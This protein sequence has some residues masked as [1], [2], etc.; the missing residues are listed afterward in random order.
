M[1]LKK[2]KISINLYVLTKDFYKGYFWKD[3][4]SKTSVLERVMRYK[5]GESTT[6]TRHQFQSHFYYKFVRYTFT[7]SCISPRLTQL[8]RS[9]CFCSRQQGGGQVCPG[10]SSVSQPVCQSACPTFQKIC[11]MYKCDVMYHFEPHL[12]SDLVPQ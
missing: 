6:F 1:K 11:K 4:R 2:T 7:M 9:C 5:L 3:R 12:A 8:V 10:L